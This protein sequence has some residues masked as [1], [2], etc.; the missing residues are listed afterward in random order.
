MEH[1]PVDLELEWQD[2][3]KQNA[4]FTFSTKL[5]LSLVV[6]IIVL[7]N[8]SGHEH[9]LAAFYVEEAVSDKQH[10]QTVIRPDKAIFVHMHLLLALFICH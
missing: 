10:L 9:P 1:P 5:V 6:I 2:E 8:T 7:L 4:G 3:L